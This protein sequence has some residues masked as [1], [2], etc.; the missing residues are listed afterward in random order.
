MV[1]IFEITTE[2]YISEIKEKVEEAAK[3][4]AKGKDKAT[5][6]VFEIEIRFYR[7]PKGY[8]KDGVPK[9]D[10]VD[11]DNV[12]KSVIDGLGPIIGY[13]RDWKNN[14]EKGAKDTHIVEIHAKKIQNIANQSDKVWVRVESLKPGPCVCEAE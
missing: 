7:K 10:D 6:C 11:L 2:K 14:R 9:A 12:V 13:R 5:K 1:W 8:H 4:A 3:E